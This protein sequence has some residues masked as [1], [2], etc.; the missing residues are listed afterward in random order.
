MPTAQFY[1]IVL[2]L[3]RRTASGGEWTLATR[4]GPIADDCG[5]TETERVELLPSNTQ[6][7]FVS[8][9]CWANIHLERVGLLPDGR[10]GVF[11]ISDACCASHSHSTT[12][13][14][15]AATPR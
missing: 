13:N 14:D 3:L 4:R 7:R 9:L 8:R 2:S 1:G 5:L 11:K 12:P 6:S 15:H 10:R